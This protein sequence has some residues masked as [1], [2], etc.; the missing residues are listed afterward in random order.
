MD[1]VLV[2]HRRSIAPASADHNGGRTAGVSGLTAFPPSCLVLRRSE[3]SRVSA[4]LF[5]IP[6]VAARFGWRLLGETLTPVACAGVLV[7][8]IGVAIVSRSA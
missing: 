6:P 1:V 8:V 5:L 3:A 7:A 4:L 2:E